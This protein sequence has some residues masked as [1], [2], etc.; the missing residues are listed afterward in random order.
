MSEN[1]PPD[2]I[3]SGNIPFPK[4]NRSPSVD[5]VNDS[6]QASYSPTKPSQ[7]K[8]YAETNSDY[9]SI[10]LLSDFYFYD[11]K[12]LSLRPIRATEQAKFNRSRKEGTLRYLVEG[13][14]ATLEPGV[15]AFDLSPADF[16]FVMYWH[17]V[18][19]YSKSP[20]IHKC[21]CTNDEHVQRVL[22]NL[23]P[24]ENLLIEEIITST[25][26][27]ETVLNAEALKPYFEPNALGTRL[28]L[29]TSTMRDVVTIL[30]KQDE[31]LEDYAEYEWLADLAS[32]LVSDGQGNTSLEAR[33]ERV[34]VLCPDDIEELQ[35]YIADASN[36][37]VAEST[38]VRCK[39]CG[40][41]IETEVSINALSFLPSP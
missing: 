37:G 14:S 25:S 21:R 15:S 29:G 24:A 33:I 5:I 23:E 18:N 30:D 34:K 7:S 2:L 20:Y 16:Y 4:G 8:S 35:K 12:A 6:P 36:Y 31:G 39:G 26:L 3:S 17:K 40:A 1:T 41:E 10:T 28:H 19:S 32:F 22:D 38:V 11:F 9:V 27:K 13:I